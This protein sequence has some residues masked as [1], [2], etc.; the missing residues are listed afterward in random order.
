MGKEK[1]IGGFDLIQDNSEG[2]GLGTLMNQNITTETHLVVCPSR[3]GR[4]PCSHPAHQQE[5]NKKRL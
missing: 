3:A 2:G 5:K 1:H 4:M